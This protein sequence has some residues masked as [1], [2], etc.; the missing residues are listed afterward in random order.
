[1]ETKIKSVEID[2]LNNQIK[3]QKNEAK[4]QEINETFF[5]EGE[6]PEISLI[7]DQTELKSCPCLLSETKISNDSLSICA[8]Q[9][10]TLSQTSESSVFISYSNANFQQNEK[11]DEDNIPFYY[12]VKEYFLKTNPEKFTEYTTTKNYIHKNIYFK[13]KPKAEYYNQENISINNYYYFP[14][15]Y[16]PMNSF[17]FNHFSKVIIKNYNNNKTI[18]END[19]VNEKEN[20]GDAAKET[21]KDKEEVN[22]VEKKEEQKKEEQMEENSESLKE[23]DSQ[24]KKVFNTYNNSYNNRKTHYYNNN[25]KKAYYNNQRY[26]KNNNRYY[27][28]YSNNNYSDNYYQE[29]RTSY[30]NNSSY[31][32][33]YQKPF[34]N[35]FYYYK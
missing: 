18:K 31:K 23:K 24:N 19:K 9:A 12:G 1:M 10:E 29:G 17:Y 4:E 32:R 33:R 13:P 21:S 8:S 16:C 15:V 22:F 5:K 34:E 3:S 27:N 6:L 28:K 26:T 35:K 2:L 30:Y 20:N 7:S 14:I 25:N 11:K